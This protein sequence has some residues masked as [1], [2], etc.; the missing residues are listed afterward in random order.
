MAAT[1]K[2]SSDSYGGGY[3]NSN[4]YAGG[5][6]NSNNYYDGGWDDCGPCR[7]SLTN[8]MRPRRPPC[9]DARGASRATSS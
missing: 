4:S 9:P 1:Y 8:V 5:C 2:N 6:K 3:S 7:S